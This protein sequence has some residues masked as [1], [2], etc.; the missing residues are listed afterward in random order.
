MTVLKKRKIRKA[1]GFSCYM[2]FSVDGNGERENEFEYIRVMSNRF[3]CPSNNLRGRSPLKTRYWVFEYVGPW[4]SKKYSNEEDE[5]SVDVEG[6]SPPEIVIPTKDEAKEE[7]KSDELEPEESVVIPDV[8]EPK[9][10]K[11]G[12][13]PSAKKGGN[14]A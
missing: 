4:D 3:K 1:A 9:K 7:P 5:S 11:R 8:P 2:R 10:N 6:L 12:R 14:D 13:K